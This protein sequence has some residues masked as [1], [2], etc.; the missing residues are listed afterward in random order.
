MGTTHVH[1]SVPL[2]SD[3]R[4]FPW[5]ILLG[6]VLLPCLYLPSLGTDFDFTDDGNLVYPSPPMSLSARLALVWEKIEANVEHLGPFRPVLW[7]HWEA[8][9]ELCRGDAYGWRLGRLGWCMLATGMFLWLLREL[10]VPAPAALGAAALAMW[11]PYRNEIWTSLTLAEGVAMPYAFLALVCAVRAG[12]S[13]RPA[14][15][16]LLGA[17]CVLAALGCK[18][19]FVALIPAQLFLRVAPDGRF[20]RP[21]VRR[22]GRAACLLSLTLLLPVGH[23]VYFQ[24]HWHP[25]QYRPALPS[26]AQ[27]LRLLRGLFGAIS[28]EYMGLGLV[29]AIAL[30]A[31][32]R[33]RAPEAGTARRYQAAVVAGLLLLL[34]GFCVYLPMDAV[35]GRYTMPAVWGL[36]ILL[37]VLGG[38]LCTLPRTR[39]KSAACAALALGLVVT[40][41]ALVGKQQKFAARAQVLWDALVCI[42]RTAP[43][44]CRI[45]WISRDGPACANGLNIAEGI[46]FEWHLHARGR[47]DLHVVLCNDQGEPQTRREVAGLDRQPTLL[48][49]GSPEPPASEALGAAWQ[50]TQWCRESYWWGLAWFD[51]HLF[52]QAAAPPERTRGQGESSGAA[53]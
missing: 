27:A 6:A 28:P 14:G 41:G 29:L 22:H 52:Q 48:L 32:N 19:T 50:G 11:N 3:R 43:P 40:A 31:H 4:R 17:L 7:A 20:N 44:D 51:C 21:A 26:A 10:G 25:G 42:E 13:D 12:R 53:E 18:N 9:A 35:S 24:T 8:A 37:A 34:A 15:W 30:V 45:A 2:D 46:H 23:F 36:D 39:G 47:T 38:A 33:L 49:S 16:D 5:W 1:S